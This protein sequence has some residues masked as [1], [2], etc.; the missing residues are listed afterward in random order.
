MSAAVVS[1]VCCRPPRDSAL[2]AP[3]SI[4]LSLRAAPAAGTSGRSSFFSP[5][6]GKRRSLGERKRDRRPAR[7]ARGRGWGSARRR[8]SDGRAARPITGRRTVTDCVG[9]IKKRDS[10][11]EDHRNLPEPEDGAETPYPFEDLI[12]LCSS[13]SSPGALVQS[14]AASRCGERSRKNVERNGP[15][16]P[17]PATLARPS[18]H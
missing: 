5:L 6:G 4:P 9:T 7:H 15:P 2:P 16:S 18:R 10:R 3:R 11:K 12:P 14:T 17:L 13:G 8:N 1:P